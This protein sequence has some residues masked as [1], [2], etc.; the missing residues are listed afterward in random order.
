MARG[1][2][3]GGPSN[4]RRQRRR[5]A[6]KRPPPRLPRPHVTVFTP[7][8]AEEDDALAIRVRGDEPVSRVVPGGIAANFEPRPAAAIP[9]PHAAAVDGDLLGILV[10]EGD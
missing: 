7:G 6:Q 8:A 3:G 5:V 4:G 2:V 10:V 1:V 9:R